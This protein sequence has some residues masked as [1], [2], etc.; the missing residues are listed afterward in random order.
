M[1]DQG[2]SFGR[3]LGHLRERRG[4]SLRELGMISGVDHA[5]I[6]RLETGEKESPSKEIVE[7]LVRH[8]KPEDREAA[9]LRILS[10]VDAP[11][12]LV[13]LVL[14]E[15]FIDLR[16]FQSAAQMNYRGKARP[17]WSEVIGHIRT[18]R[19]AIERG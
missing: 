6:H 13:D 1:P 2:N 12:D 14:S 11:Q 19:K 15:E 10:E 17:K 5:Y 8:L 7:R 18:A 16:D 4:L 9:V 3:L